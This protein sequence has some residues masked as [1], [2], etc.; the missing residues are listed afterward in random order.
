MQDIIELIRVTKDPEMGFTDKVKKTIEWRD[1]ISIEEAGQE[2]SNELGQVN[3]VM[4]TLSYTE[5]IV[6]GSYTALKNKWIKFREDVKKE[7]NKI[8]NLRSKN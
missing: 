4:L 1:V 8:D 6:E 3:L 5:I 2:V 7:E